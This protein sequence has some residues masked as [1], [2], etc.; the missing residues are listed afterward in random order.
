MSPPP[1]STA[2]LL[3]QLIEGVA[4]LRRDI[5]ELREDFDEEK[6][7]DRDARR[8]MHRKIDELTDR[9][10]KVEGKIEIAGQV[11]AQ[12]RDRIDDV[13]ADVTERL[14]GFD[15]TLTVDVTPTVEEFKRMKMIGMSVV[16]VVALGGTAFGA[17][18]IWWGEQ[19]VATIR[20]LLR[21][22]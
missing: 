3:G 20:S 17:S 21:I 18:L 2:Y 14:D 13:S 12:T 4:G 8:D 1:Q 11:T 10:G 7:H 22:P 19:V 15:K 9:V 6:G 5:T 16:G